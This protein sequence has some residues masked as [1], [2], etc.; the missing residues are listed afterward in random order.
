MGWLFGRKKG[1]AKTEEKPVFSDPYAPYEDKGRNYTYKI[2]LEKLSEFPDYRE[3]KDWTGWRTVPRPD[4]KNPFTGEPIRFP[5]PP[6]SWKEFE[7]CV[8]VPKSRYAF[9][10]DPATGRHI[11]IEYDDHYGYARFYDPDGKL[12]GE[13]RW[14]RKEEGGEMIWTKPK[15]TKERAKV[16]EDFLVN[17]PLTFGA[18]WFLLPH[19]SARLIAT[20]GFPQDRVDEAFRRKAVV[21]IC[22]D[23]LGFIGPLV[24]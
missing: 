15:D 17:S 24:R 20:S 5:P 23:A 19:C 7:W 6:E 22:S 11:K 13:F 16:V 8:F 9:A 2:P 18:T 4:L 12:R 14:E 1:E 3:K 21:A 10:I